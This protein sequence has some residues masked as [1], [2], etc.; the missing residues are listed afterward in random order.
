MKTRRIVLLA[1]G[2]TAFA[3]WSRADVDV[4]AVWP[5]GILYNV[6]WTKADSPYRVRCDLF[7][8]LLNIEPGVRV[9]FEGNHEFQVQG[10]LIARGTAEEPIT[11]TSAYPGA[12]TWKGILFENSQPDCELVHC[13][14]EHSN[15]SG[16]RVIECAPKIE[17]CMI[18]KNTADTEASGNGGGIYASVSVR[19]LMKIEK[20]A[21][22]DNASRGAGGGLYVNGSCG[23]VNCWIQG[24]RTLSPHTGGGFFTGGTVTFRNCMITESIGTPFS[25]VINGAA[26][27]TNCLFYNNSN[28]IQIGGG[29]TITNCTLAFFNGSS[30]NIP[31][32]SP[33]GLNVVNSIFYYNARPVL[34]KIFYSYCNIQDLLPSGVGNIDLPPRFQSSTDLHLLPGSPCIDAGDP[35]IAY[36]D[37]CF[38]PSLGTSRSDMGAFGGPGACDWDLPFDC[39]TNGVLDAEDIENKWSRDCNANDIPDE[40]DIGAGR[41]QDSDGDGIID[42]CRERTAEIVLVR[43][44]PVFTFAIRFKSDV[45]FVGGEAAIGFDPAVLDLVAV[46]RGADFPAGAASFFCPPECPEG[47][48]SGCAEPTG[49][50]TMAWHD[51][52]EGD[53]TPA[54]TYDLFEVDLAFVEGAPPGKSSPVEFVD[55]LGPADARVRN[56]L[57]G[58]DGRSLP[59]ITIGTRSL[60]E[61]FRRGDAND[62]G[63]HDISDPISVLLFLFGGRA[64][65]P[66]K[67]AADADDSGALDITDAVYLLEW[68]FKSGTQPPAPFPA[69][70][71]DPTDDGLDPCN[72]RSCF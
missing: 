11:F 66:C 15:S 58:A 62:D 7:V 20:C 45:P 70:D 64:S 28:P 32:F 48:I 18:R 51:D 30:V 31:E 57:T 55:C 46:R 21:I 61:T 3:S 23:L 41:A 52:P 17:G 65:L 49:G 40:C 2:F 67:D 26:N 43:S 63:A 34:S 44:S 56:I 71:R 69:C 13:I 19:G 14:V 1:A 37:S 60:P 5:D 72:Y 38:P 10:T 68:R 24:N 59:L 4:C 25:F 29:G 53:P 39:N 6:T 50:V 36:N 8:T 27:L 54:G 9:L 33:Q 35:D 42:A 12:V 47:L 16:V 22:V